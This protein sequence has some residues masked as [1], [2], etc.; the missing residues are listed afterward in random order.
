MRCSKKGRFNTGTMIFGVLHVRGHSLAASPPARITAFIPGKFT[1]HP[2]CTSNFLPSL[3]FFY[4]QLAHR[5]CLP[6]SIITLSSLPL[7][8]NALIYRDPGVLG[9]FNFRMR[10][11]NSQIKQGDSNHHPPP[12]TQRITTL[13][14]FILLIFIVFPLF[15]KLIMS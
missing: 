11:K 10:G 3:W 7:Y 12:I 5:N 9:G 13:I 2:A 14:M 8:L 1:P 6:M 15:D 4:K